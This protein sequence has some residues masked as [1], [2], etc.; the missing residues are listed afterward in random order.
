MN[1]KQ[2]REEQFV[3]IGD[4]SPPDAERLLGALTRARIKF[5]IECDDG[6]RFRASKMG[7]F[8][9]YAKVRVFIKCGQ[10]PEVTKIQTSLFA[11]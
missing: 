11:E 7:N 2:K 3:S 4:Y 6:I 10:I 9:Q 8:G 1:V 5:E